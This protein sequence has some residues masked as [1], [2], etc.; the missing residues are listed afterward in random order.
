MARRLSNP[1]RGPAILEAAKSLV[2]SAALILNLEGVLE[3]EPQKAGTMVAAKASVKAAATAQTPFLLAMDHDESLARLLWVGVR[4]VVV[5]NNHR[6]DF[7]MMRYQ[8]MCQSLKKAGLSIINGKAFQ[9]FGHF[10][11]IAL[12][13]LDN[14]D[15]RRVALLTERDI[16]A[17]PIPLLGKPAFA[18]VHWGSEGHRTIG[19]R[20]RTI[21]AWLKARGIELVIG[22][23]PHVARAFEV[24]R[25]FACAFSLGNFLFDQSAPPAGGSI[26]ELRF[27]PQGTYF[28]R[29]RPIGNL[30]N[31]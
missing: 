30:Y 25:E 16:A 9:D 19:E 5:E 12:T 3:N 8:N 14:A 13:D 23:H 24:S 11:L 29:L 15:P 20:E 4:A 1:S 7:G 26:L 22:C 2:G 27:F 28:L 17:L 10:S 6:F 21:A 31:R 18:F